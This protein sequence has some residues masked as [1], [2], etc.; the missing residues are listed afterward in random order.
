[1]NLKQEIEKYSEVNDND[2]I[3]I[4][5]SV[6]FNILKTHNIEVNK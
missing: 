1:M 5:L 4:N 6:L 3:V 2:E